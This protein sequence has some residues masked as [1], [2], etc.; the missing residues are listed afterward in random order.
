MTRNKVIVRNGISTRRL[1]KPGADRVRRVISRLVNEMVVLTPD[2]ITVMIAMSCAPIPVK[3]VLDENGVMKVHPDMVKD[4]LLDF[5]RAFFFSRLV[6]SCVVMYHRESEALVRVWNTK[7]LGAMSKNL[8]EP[9][10]ASDDFRA[11]VVVSKASFK[12]GC[13]IKLK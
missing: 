1:R 9:V 8:N 13:L 6:F 5:G 2:K 11:V 4:E 12:D 3:R 10:A 7:A